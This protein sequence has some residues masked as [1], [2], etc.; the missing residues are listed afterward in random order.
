MRDRECRGTEQADRVHSSTV[1]A[2]NLV[3][4]FCSF[5]GFH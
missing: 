1:Q 4:L 2:Q 3:V 5:N